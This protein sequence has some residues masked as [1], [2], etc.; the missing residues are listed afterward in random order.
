MNGPGDDLDQPVF[1]RLD[2]C[3]P[4]PYTRR[5]YAVRFLWRFVQAT[6]FRWSPPRAWGWRRWLLRCFG[7]KV[8]DTAGVRPSTKVFHPW[9]LSM[10]A[11]SMLADGV[12]VYNLGPV[13]IGAHSTVSQDTYICAGTH[14]YS[15]RDLPLRRP[16][17]TIGDGV[18]VAAQAFIGPG[19]TIHN[20]AV[21]G[22]RSMVARDVP[23]GMIVAGNPARVIRPR[24][25]KLERPRPQ[26]SSS[27]S[28]HERPLRVLHLLSLS[29]AGGLSRYVFD[30][31]SAMYPM[32]HEVAVAGM[33]GPWHWLFEESPWPWIDVPLV[34]P[35]GGLWG[36]TRRL[37]RYLAEHP[38]DIIHSHYRRT[39]ML[40]RRLQRTFDIPV[41]YTLHLSHLRVGPVARAFT[42]F[43]DHV[44]VAS[45]DARKWLVNDMGFPAARTTLIPHGIDPNRFPIADARARAAAREA[46]RIPPDAT[47][48]AYVG[49]LDTPKNEGWMIDLALAARDRI[50]N[51]CVLMVGE[52]PHEPELRRRIAESGVQSTVSLL[53]YRD[54]LACYQAADLVLLPSAQEGFSLV[55]AE[56][57]SVGVPVLR[58]RT[59]GTTEL[60]VE[61]VTGRA[62]PIQK[63]AFINAALAMLAD[64]HALRRMG[65]AAAEHIRGRFSFDQQVNDTIALYRRLIDARRGRTPS[66]HDSALP[67]AGDAGATRA[68]AAAAA[69]RG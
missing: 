19:V 67:P 7:A 15:R 36:A 30:L 14:D 20:N 64:P 41:L 37:R 13:S 22:A 58:T 11:R 60:I 50:P 1:Q 28:S 2:L 34:R 6:L 35:V 61:N 25:M 32:G 45:T 65:A 54:P 55:C 69:P 66:R 48:A 49:R 10:G 26:L 44:H 16:P 31:C 47:V 9:L 8:A 38:V 17:I 51:L 21:V 3:Q 12:I 42:D 29:D 56:A 4:Y 23:A 33:R 68:T 24:P 53:G 40:G 18:W 39:N 62:V 52:G 5:E 43:G 63:D 57:M 27:T 46:L 59:S